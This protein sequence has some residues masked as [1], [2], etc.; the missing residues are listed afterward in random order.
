MKLSHCLF[1]P[2][3]LVGLG[4]LAACSQSP[5]PATS[6]TATTTGGHSGS[7]AAPMAAGDV[8][9]P[10]RLPGT[11]WQWAGFTGGE[12]FTVANPASYTLEFGSDGRVQVKADCNKGSGPVKLGAG[13]ISINL[14]QITLTKCGADS[15]GDQF[16]AYLSQAEKWSIAGSQLL[17]D[18]PNGRGQMR[19]SRS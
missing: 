16:Q 14:L 17:L 19:F 2:A 12:S 4:G 10:S 18:L 9:N 8:T 1:V 6:S 5:K 7:T 13:T 11:T 15:R 3:L